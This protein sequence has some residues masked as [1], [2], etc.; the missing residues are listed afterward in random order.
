[1]AWPAFILVHALVLRLAAPD[2]DSLPRNAA[3]TIGAL[4][5]AALGAPEGRA[6]TASWGGPSSAWPWLGWMAV[7]AL[8]LF[9]IERPRTALRW[10][11]SAAPGAYRTAVAGVLAVGLTFWTLVA[12]AVSDG[13]ANPLP[14]VP[15][16]NPLD[17]A[18]GSA[19]LAAWRWFDSAETNPRP[20]LQFGAVFAAFVWLNAILL[21][22]FHHYA[23]VPYRLDA[24]SGSLTVQTAVTLLW[25]ATA[26]IVMWLS[27]RRTARVP[28]MGGAALL[29]AVPM[30]MA[31]ANA[32]AASE[33]PK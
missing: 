6:I 10:P 31:A 20:A 14:H 25:A 27:A 16:L 3:H 32:S 9:W 26:L 7:P 8:V 21:R 12:N 18:I 30:R 28:W 29:G 17:L 5:I 33:R 1:M 23:A 19:L 15:L 2:W 13:S 22:G 11:V 4:V 24:W